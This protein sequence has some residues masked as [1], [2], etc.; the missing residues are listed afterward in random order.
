MHCM[1][2]Q[3]ES[4]QT[5]AAAIPYLVLQFPIPLY[6][7]RSNFRLYTLNRQDKKGDEQREDEGEYEEP[8]DTGNTV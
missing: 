7:H 1:L 4:S 8:A 6:Y 5:G 3:L 2:T